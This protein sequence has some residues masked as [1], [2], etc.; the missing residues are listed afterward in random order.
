[1][2]TVSDD[3]HRLTAAIG[4]LNRL[5]NASEV[6]DSLGE[7]GD[8]VIDSLTTSVEWSRHPASVWQ[9]PEAG[10]PTASTENFCALELRLAEL[11]NVKHLPR[12]LGILT[13]QER[14]VVLLK[15]VESLPQ[16]QIARNLSITPVAVSQILSRALEKLRN[17]PEAQDPLD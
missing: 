7:D 14:R 15:L 11:T 9:V 5:P 3:D 1:M 10:E 6:A 2:T 12:L 17:N 8:D 4:D 16:S 13:H